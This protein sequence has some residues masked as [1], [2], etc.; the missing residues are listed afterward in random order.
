MTKKNDFSRFLTKKGKQSEISNS[1]S[2]FL[3]KINEN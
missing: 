3:T 1:S 2:I